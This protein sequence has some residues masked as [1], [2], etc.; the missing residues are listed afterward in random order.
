MIPACAGMAG[1]RG[2]RLGRTG[3]LRVSPNP[4]LHEW[5]RK[6][7]QNAA[8]SPRVPLGPFFC[9]PQEWGPEG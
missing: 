4:P 1:G 9:I 3:S 8:G 7:Q 6:V 5:D 2:V